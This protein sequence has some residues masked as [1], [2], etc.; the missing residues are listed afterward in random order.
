M[1][2][3]RFTNAVLAILIIVLIAFNITLALS[4]N[5]DLFQKRDT[6]G[7]KFAFQEGYFDTVNPWGDTSYVNLDNSFGIQTSEC[8]WFTYENV[9]GISKNPNIVNGLS[10]LENGFSHLSPPQTCVD[11]DQLVFRTGRRECSG[12]GAADCIGNQGER[13]NRGTTQNFNSTCIG[14]TIPPCV[15]SIG[16]LSFNFYQDPNSDISPVDSGSRF[17]TFS[18]IFVN[19]NTFDK[20]EAD[21]T[22]QFY[23]NEGGLFRVD[24]ENILKLKDDQYAPL[25][26]FLGKQDSNFKQNIKLLRYSSDGQNYT[27]D[28]GGPYGEIMF[29]P[30]NLYLDVGFNEVLGQLS[31]NGLTP[32]I[33]PSTITAKYVDG[34]KLR[35]IT[36]NGNWY[37]DICTATIIADVISVNIY[38]TGTKNYAIGDLVNIEDDSGSGSSLQMKVVATKDLS[39]YFILSTT[40]KKWLLLPPMNIGGGQIIPRR[41]RTS[42]MRTMNRPLDPIFLDYVT[43][44]YSPN[45]PSA[46]SSDA[47][48]NCFAK[49][50]PSSEF[51]FGEQLYSGQPSSLVVNNGD[52]CLF[53]NF[54]TNIIGGNDGAM[55]AQP[56]DT[57]FGFWWNMAER[58]EREFAGVTQSD[59][60]KTLKADAYFT[61]G[62]NGQFIPSAPNLGTIAAPL[63]PDNYIEDYLKATNK[64][65]GVVDNFSS[66]FMTLHPY[67]GSLENDFKCGFLGSNDCTQ[68]KCALTYRVEYPAGF[69]PSYS[70]DYKDGTVVWNIVDAKSQINV[71]GYEYFTRS[72]VIGSGVSDFRLTKGGSTYAQPSSGVVQSVDFSSYSVSSGDLVDKGT[73]TKVTLEGDDSGANSCKVTVSFQQG[74][75]SSVTI[76]DPGQGY[77]DGESCSVKIPASI[78]TNNGNVIVLD[79]L[80]VSAQDTNYVYVAFT[81]IDGTAYPPGSGDQTGIQSPATSY[82]FTLDPDTVVIKS[83]ALTL[84]KSPSNCILA[85][86]S[87]Y[88]L[89][90]QIAICQLDQNL[91]S[92]VGSAKAAVITVTRLQNSSEPVKVHS[93]IN[94]VD[95]LFPTGP[96]ID[97]FTY[98]FYQPDPDLPSEQQ[99]VYEESPQQIG[100]IDPELESEMNSIIT[101]GGEDQIKQYLFKDSP[102]GITNIVNIP[103]LQFESL[104]Y[105]AVQTGTDPSP[106]DIVIAPGDTLVVGKFIPYT[107]FSSAIRDGANLKYDKYLFNGNNV[108]FIPN[109]ITDI[110]TRQFSKTGKDALPTF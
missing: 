101:T 28:S 47:N 56:S 70:K 82:G 44:K 84:N 7:E 89:N 48:Q 93:L 75:I 40:P 97:Y 42:Y 41:D 15:S 67:Y 32:N 51:V 80:V 54:R 63:Y 10:D 37:Q 33:N 71:F 4:I 95:P 58:D 99:P 77:Y 74:T 36:Y 26:R 102:G 22:K 87:G 18:Q 79:N 39:N 109:S 96:P 57:E 68:W 13:Y 72:S 35:K 43:T 38:K 65:K 105:Q 92:V 55:N 83:G 85:G 30:Q 100:Y 31:S 27:A 23:I 78:P 6:S 73:Y 25:I 88:S 106:S 107:K 20:I 19:Q 86:G 103:T 45:G 12:T 69:V 49:V 64:Q 53:R 11:E 8:N 94:P 2:T 14:S 46:Q 34:N 81:Y 29:R 5:G 104:N 52:K 98:N 108:R 3:E 24:S 91:T 110:Y 21:K 50:T 60:G 16:S 9:F 1:K 90:D 62:Y 66:D 17:L 76:S 59:S 61:T